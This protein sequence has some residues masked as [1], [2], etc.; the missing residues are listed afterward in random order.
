MGE[1]LD[2]AILDAHRA[3]VFQPIATIEIPRIVTL[4]GHVEGKVAVSKHKHVHGLVVRRRQPFQTELDQMF[5]GSLRERLFA[6]L[7]AVA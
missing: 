6:F 2:L 3:H 1:E 5:L 7:S 4:E